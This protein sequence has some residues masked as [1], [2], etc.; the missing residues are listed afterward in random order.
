MNISCM[1]KVEVDSFIAPKAKLSVVKGAQVM[2][3]AEHEDRLAAVD[4]IPIE[5]SM[6]TQYFMDVGVGTPR[7]KFTVFLAP[8][9]CSD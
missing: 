4:R 2:F 6:G 3:P 8:R 5:N 9:T 1:Y 7:Q